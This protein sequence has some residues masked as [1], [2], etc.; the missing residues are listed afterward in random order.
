MMYSLNEI[1]GLIVNKRLMQKIINARIPVDRINSNNDESIKKKSLGEDKIDL[2][3]DCFKQSSKIYG[4]V[5]KSGDTNY[6]DPYKSSSDE[7][8]MDFRTMFKV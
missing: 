6:N 7:I 1:F 3:N 2:F 4:N 5:S 8:I